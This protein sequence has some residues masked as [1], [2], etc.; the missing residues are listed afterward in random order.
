MKSGSEIRGGM[1]AKED[2]RHTT[3]YPGVSYRIKKDP[4]TG[5]PERIF[6]IR[7]RVRRVDGGWK[8]VEEAV[9][10][11]FRDDM[12]PA[13]AS[14]IRAKR[15]H[16]DELPNNERRAEAAR[17]RETW[18]I[19]RLWTSYK[20][21]KPDL[22]SYP[23]YNSLYN[24]YLAH[25][26]DKRPQDITPFD[27][28][29]ISRRYT[30]GK[31]VKTTASVLE[32]L[33][34]I[35]NFGVKRGLCDG[36]GFQIQLPQVNNE[37]TEDLTPEQMAR[38]LE[39]IDGHIEYRT[40]CQMGAEMMLLV[41]Y[42]GMRRGELFRLKWDDIDRHRKN[43]TLRD[44][45]SGRNEIIPMSSYASDLLENIKKAGHRSDHVFPGRSGGKLVDIR[46]QVNAI[47][48]EAILP[49]DFRAL[50]GL[51][52]VFA[53]MLISEGISKD[54]VGKLLTHAGKANVTDRYAH[55][56]FDTLRDAAELA[57][58]LV[59]DARAGG[60]QVVELKR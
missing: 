35:V 55:V 32:L 16:G 3:K 52:H 38:L 54:I 25:L 60:G 18:T 1:M 13:R 2:K 46:R 47:K 9:G 31:S 5:K 12:T 14:H 43:I 6:Y 17:K 21:V 39:K 48:A 4:A 53:S 56:R 57:G 51:R 42:T 58:R 7:Y 28:D 34:R 8:Q 33:R 22:K 29:K 15:M 40:G 26:G 30:K 24:R 11:Q 23:A 36:P 41:L 37:K 45:K 59:A 20:E 19:A 50:H 10:S 44:A 27:I 49:E